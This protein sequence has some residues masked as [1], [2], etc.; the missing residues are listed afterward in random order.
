[1]LATSLFLAGAPGN[2]LLWAGLGSLA[3]TL[4][5]LAAN[6]GH[7]RYYEVD[8]RARP[9]QAL[10]ATPPPEILSRRPTTTRRFLGAGIT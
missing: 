3:V 2:L 6:A 9:I 10:S 1:M 7:Y 4:A 5:A 8:H